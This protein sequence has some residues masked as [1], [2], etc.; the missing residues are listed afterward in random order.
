MADERTVPKLPGQWAS[1]KCRARTL[2][3]ARLRRA[4]APG[5]ALLARP[6][7]LLQSKV[8]GVRGF[9]FGRR[10]I[11]WTPQGGYQSDAAGREISGLEKYFD[12]HTIGPGIWKW[13]HYFDVYDRHLAR[14][15]GHD[16]HILEI[17]VYSGGSLD[18]WRDYF[19]TACQVYGVDIESSCRAYDKQGIKVFIGDQADPRFWRELL[20]EIPRIDVVV[21]DGGHFTWQQV[22]AFEAVIG[23][24]SPGGVYICEDIHGTTNGFHEYICGLSRNINSWGGPTGFQRAIDSV[25]IYPFIT[26]V[27][28]RNIPLAEMVLARQGTQWQPFL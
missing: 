18:M 10:Q 5:V 6:I 23:A 28:K 8:W 27:E 19:G 21:D 12:A 7:E 20:S 24:L 11:G 26:V 14:F 2:I 9:R 3:P 15:R 4:L 13:R 16:V 25:H 22:P 17:G 1:R